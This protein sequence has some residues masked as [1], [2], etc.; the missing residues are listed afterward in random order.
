M[1]ETLERRTIVAVFGGNKVPQDVLTITHWIGQQIAAH[2]FIVLT[3]G[4][5]PGLRRVKEVAIDGA[6]PHGRW[7]GVLNNSGGIP[8]VTPVGRG[9]VVSPQMADQPQLPGGEP[10]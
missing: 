5:M 3:G 2:G 4:E 6:G 7:I 10:M 8:H 9:V 1:T